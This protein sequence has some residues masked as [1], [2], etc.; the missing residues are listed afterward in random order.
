MMRLD[1]RS[2]SHGEIFMGIINFFAII[3]YNCVLLSGTKYIVAKE[4]SFTLLNRLSGAPKSPVLVFTLSIV[5]FL[6]LIALM[7]IHAHLKSDNEHDLEFLIVELFVA[8]MIIMVT[9]DSYNGIILFVAADT[10]YHTEHRKYWYLCTILCSLLWLFS[11]NGFM[12]TLYRMPSIND[13]IAFFPVGKRIAV[14]FIK[15]LITSVNTITFIVFLINI[16]LWEH[17]LLD[18]AE[19]K[20]QIA[21]KVNSDLEHYVQLIEKI[22]EDNERKRIARELHDTLGHVLAGISAGLEAGILL[23]KFDMERAV[24]QLE[25]VQESLREGTADVRRSLQKLRPNALEQKSFMEALEYMIEDYR[26]LTALDIQLH[27]EWYGVKLSERA[28]AML[29]RVVQESITNSLRHGHANTI[30]INLF[31]NTDGFIVTIQD[32][33]VGFDELHYGYGLTQMKERL[34]DIGGKV[35]FINA[36]GFRTYIEI[37]RNEGVMDN[38]ENQ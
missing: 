11:Q 13:Y 3:F 9:N 4:L 26:Q 10:Y 12:D 24:T 29:Y 2:L 1:N 19:E 23:L 15:N 5:L 8:M 34:A 14:L 36:G 17:K 16:I 20:I 33:G 35:E 28:E 25:K 6:V 27:E 32:D 38:D 31:T 37:P 7:Y 30:E 22:A 18:L 21:A